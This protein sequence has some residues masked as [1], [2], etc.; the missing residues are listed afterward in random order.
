MQRAPEVSS[1]GEVT[2][3]ESRQV[4]AEDGR[5]TA[6][7]LLVNAL[8]ATRVKDVF[9][10][11]GG[12]I[13]PFADALQRSPL[14]LWHTRHEAGA[15]FCATEASFATGRPAGVFTT[16]GPGLTNAITGLMAARWDGA[17]VVLV[18]GGTSAARRGRWGV[19][20]TSPYTTPS[21]FFNAGPLFDFAA[22]IADVGEIPEVARRLAQGFRRPQGFV[23]HVHVP[24]DLQSELVAARSFPSLA[25]T[26]AA[27]CREAVSDCVARL[28]VPILVGHGARHAGAAI[29]E[30]AE[31]TGAAL[32]CSPRAK[33]IVP[34]THPQFVGVTGV[35]GHTEVADFLQAER[36][37]HVLV[38]GSRLGEVTSCWSPV[39][40]PGEGFIHVDLDP[41]AFG[42][43]YPDVPTVGIQSEVGRFV[44]ALLGELSGEPRPGPH[45]RPLPAQTRLAPR[46]G[47]LVRPQFLMQACQELVVERSNAVVM[48]ESGNA[49]GW[50]N[51]LLRFTE[52]G[53]YRTSAAFGAMG[54][55]VTGVVG[56][57]LARE[58]KALAVVGDGAMLMNNEISTAVKY[59]ADAI[60]LVLNDGYYGITRHAMTAQGFEPVETELPPNRFVDFARSMGADG[61]RVET[62][63]EVEDALGQA[64]AHRG[65]F[66]V[67]VRI[68]P[69]EVT[70]VLAGRVASLEK[71]RA[72]K[73]QQ[74]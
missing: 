3:W 17:S 19:Q 34:E 28:P 35:G 38:L 67:D 22:T 71:Q 31:R 13:A 26:P 57:A 46:D 56:A 69:T 32:M 73:E 33:G 37:D 66:V 50:G 61:V 29:V 6:A 20:E 49:F 18:S 24:L 47:G 45:L 11:V 5:V 64:L 16:T 72:D 12:G 58:G 52:P 23:A 54:H 7:Q 60:W 9:G 43:A 15:A 8:R 30:L 70:P 62:E 36:P 27:P 41:A 55:F 21:D 39:L 1:R 74:R 4:L 51:H 65:P 68:D 2:G 44:S 53:R 63:R 48:T 40:V 59:E 42:A 10:V 25:H 14:S